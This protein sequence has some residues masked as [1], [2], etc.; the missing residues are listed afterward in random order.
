MAM[1]QEIQQKTK[2][3]FC[4]RALTPPNS[5]HQ[6]YNYPP[7][8]LLNPQLIAH[9]TAALLSAWPFHS[10]PYPSPLFNGW[11]LMQSVPFESKPLISPLMS[12]HE[13]NNNNYIEE[14]QNEIIKS[15]KKN[16]SYSSHASTSTPIS[17]PA[18]HSSDSIESSDHH[19]K[20]HHHHQQH[21]YG[22]GKVK[23][24]ACKVCDKTFGYKHVLQNHEKT[25]T[26]EK[27]HVCSVC[28]KRFRRD[29]HLKVHMRLHSGERPYS[30]T[31]PN[32]D[33]QFAQVANLRR[34]MK[35]HDEKNKD[36][37]K[38]QMSEI[39]VMR[40][41]SGDDCFELTMKRHASVTPDYD[42]YSTTA[43]YPEQTEPEDLSMH[44]ARKKN[45]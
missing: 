29:H 33:R 27:S 23:V 32:C 16:V 31:F 44:A 18:S 14:N 1:L 35:T 7:M 43:D 24:F 30:C 45:C 5:D 42:Y 20:E 4:D 17:S 10:L 28:N 15:E 6:F 11:P 26:G 41:T 2:D 21:P 34:H 9:Q 22:H 3:K 37:E 36:C 8:G 12:H 13:K 38:V 19:K 25:H 40:A 39:R